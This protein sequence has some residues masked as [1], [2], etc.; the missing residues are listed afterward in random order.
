VYGTDE[1]EVSCGGM[2]Y[3]VRRLQKMDLTFFHAHGAG[4]AARQRAINIDGWLMPAVGTVSSRVQMRFRNVDDGEIHTLER[5]FGRLQKNFRLHGRM[6]PGSG[7]AQYQPG[8]LMLL[9]LNGD[10]ITWALLRNQGKEQ[11]LYSYLTDTGHVLWRRNMGL[12]R[13]SRSIRRLEEMLGQF[14]A[15]LFFSDEMSGLDEEPKSPAVRRALRR[16]MTPQEFAALQRTWERN[17]GLGERFV[18]ERE[19]TRLIAAG[20][21]D[22][23]ARVE[24]VSET[25]PTSP[26]DVR[27]FEGA[28][29]KPDA[30][31]YIEVKATSG[32]GMEFEMSEAEWVFAEDK[33]Q[34]HMVYRVTKVTSAAP[35]C[36]EFRDIVAYFLAS[37]SIRRPTSFKVR[38][39]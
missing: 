25:D 26:Y 4:A 29:P 20:H 8:D 37:P 39:V 19:R 38:I 22:L 28:A 14:D 31:R 10:H 27:S 9:R 15:A 35:G 11:A 12:V 17:G 2:A 36:V 23:A 34:E 16:V 13:D 18:V 1:L 30:D 24:H 21:P 7:Y 33:R 6:V 3:L 32:T 5:R